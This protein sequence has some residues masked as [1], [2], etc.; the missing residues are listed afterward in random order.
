MV[1]KV[2]GYSVTSSLFLI[3]ISPDFFQI[4][5][6]W[7]AC[8]HKQV[9]WLLFLYCHAHTSPISEKVVMG[10]SPLQCITNLEKQIPVLH[11]TDLIF[12]L[13]KQKQINL[14][15]VLLLASILIID[16]PIE[17]PLTTNSLLITF[18]KLTSKTYIE[19]RNIGMKCSP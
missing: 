6:T 10:G 12:Y 16:H 17:P 9:Y 4:F 13:A 2:N 15:H 7:G 14:I 3:K 8:H 19:T 11:L 5:F 18:K 1:S